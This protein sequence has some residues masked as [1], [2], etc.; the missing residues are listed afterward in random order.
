MSDVQ[1]NNLPSKVTPK[2]DGRWRVSRSER[3]WV[4]SRSWSKDKMRIETCG[5]IE[6]IERSVYRI[7]G[8]SGEWVRYDSRYHPLHSAQEFSDLLADAKKKKFNFFNNEIRRFD[9][10]AFVQTEPAPFIFLD[11]EGPIA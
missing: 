1:Q 9:L 5:A 6:S 4:L 10:D 11:E 3:L 2:N 8:R 7:E